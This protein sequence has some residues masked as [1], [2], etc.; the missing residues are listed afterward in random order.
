MPRLGDPRTIVPNERVRDWVSINLPQ[1]FRDFADF[2]LGNSR[3]GQYAMV[4][5]YLR[6][7]PSL[8]KLDEA[9]VKRV[10]AVARIIDEGHPETDDWHVR[11]DVSSKDSAKA[12]IVLVPDMKL[13]H[14]DGKN[15]VLLSGR[16]LTA[17]RHHRH[18]YEL[19]SMETYLGLAHA[20]GMADDPLY[21][22]LTDRCVQELRDVSERLQLPRDMN[23]LQT[24]TGDAFPDDPEPHSFLSW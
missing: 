7:H 12:R 8:E 1:E 21:E 24:A 18:G 5:D 4:N 2:L 17:H 23:L 19:L 3:S 14:P 11:V 9:M 13:W 15:V 22:G 16:H 10:P 20:A 6:G